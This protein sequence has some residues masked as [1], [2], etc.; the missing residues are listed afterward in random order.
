MKQ[1]VILIILIFGGLSANAQFDADVNFIGA[2]SAFG[3]SSAR[4]DQSGFR[5]DNYLIGLEAGRFVGDKFMIGVEAQ[6][7]Q[8][9]NG[10]T[11]PTKQLSF[12][13]LLRLY[14]SDLIYGGLKYVYTDVR[15]NNTSN[16]YG[17]M[18]F[19]VGSSLMLTHKI[20][21]EPELTYLRGDANNPIR[22]ISFTFGIGLFLD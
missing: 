18:G 5:A 6:Y 11:V 15:A 22:T 10:F 3:F 16:D 12:A 8:Q 17:S 20:A 4:D 7:A 21:F 19:L 14:F 2:N 9:E 13:P 1:L